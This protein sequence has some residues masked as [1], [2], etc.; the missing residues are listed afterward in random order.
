MAETAL[1]TAQEWEEFA[2][3]PGA[4]VPVCPRCERPMLRAAVLALA[5]GIEPTVQCPACG[6][7][8]N[9]DLR[10]TLSDDGTQASDGAAAGAT[11]VAAAVADAVA[12]E[13]IRIAAQ[14]NVEV[15]PRLSMAGLR[16]GSVL[17]RTTGVARTRVEE[18]LA[19]VDASIAAMRS[20]VLGHW[21]DSEHA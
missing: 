19:E 1:Q 15:V 2:Q 4:G 20:V 12:A 13:E 7:D 8:L 14:L 5:V 18:A 17:N 11:A 3:R 10:V 6:T 21:A 9:L 16:L